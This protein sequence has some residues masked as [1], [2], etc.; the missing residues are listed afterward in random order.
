MGQTQWRGYPRVDI[1]EQPDGRVQINR[2][3]DAIDLDVQRLA[4]GMRLAEIITYTNSGTFQKGLYTGLV[5][6]LVECVGGGGG[7]AYAATPSPGNTTIARAG[8]GG[9]YTRSWF[10]AGDLSAIEVVTVGA[11]GAGGTSGSQD[12]APGGATSFGSLVTAEGG[13]GGKAYPNMSPPIFPLGETLPQSA[14]PQG[15]YIVGIHGHGPYRIYIDTGEVANG[16]QP[17]FAGAP[18]GGPYGYHIDSTLFAAR[19]YGSGAAGRLLRGSGGPVNGRAGSDGLVVV[20]VFI[21]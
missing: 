4:T 14:A 1:G 10:S 3:A 16:Y 6:V 15:D 8:C 17:A 11:G 20:W 18:S 7:S 9:A 19:G 21:S 2:L 12:G 5:G 13:P